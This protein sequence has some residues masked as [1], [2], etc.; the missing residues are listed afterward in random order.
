[1]GDED[2]VTDLVALLFEDGADHLVGGSDGAGG[3][4]DHEV[5]GPHVW[6][7]RACGGFDVG[8][9]RFVIALEGRG[10]GDDE[11]IGLDRLE[12]SLEVARL[13]GGLHQDVE[14][15]LDDVD[16]PGVD[17]LDDMWRGVHAMD[18]EALGAEQRGG[19]QADVAEAH[20]ANRLV[21]LRHA[22]WRIRRS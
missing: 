12:T 9:I 20:D 2:L 18:A 22:A 13:H 3:F 16:A 7:D 6:R 8:E 1:M 11:D 14:V 21:G 15:G 10:H 4:E 19:G 17:G 5:A